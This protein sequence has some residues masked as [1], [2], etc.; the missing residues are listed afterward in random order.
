MELSNT[1]KINSLR[2]GSFFPYENLLFLVKR[3]PVTGELSADSIGLLSISKAQVDS[4]LWPYLYSGDTPL[5]DATIVS[6]LV[7]SG[8]LNRG[9]AVGDADAIA[10]YSLGASD[11][12]LFK[13]MKVLGTIEPFYVADGAFL[14]SD[15]QPIW[16]LK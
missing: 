15:N 2:T 5:D 4:V 1:L 14:T 12:T 6:N 13:A 7:S 16:V 11:L 8:L 9:Y 10:I 3:D